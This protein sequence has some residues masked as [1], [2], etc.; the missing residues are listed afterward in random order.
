MEDYM[1]WRIG[2]GRWQNEPLT[3]QAA[4]AVLEKIP[5]PERVSAIDGL[6]ECDGAA[7]KSL[8][9]SRLKRI[10]FHGRSPGDG[11]LPAYCVGIKI[12]VI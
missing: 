7:I 5:Y 3:D 1:K 11:A 9:N 10:P 4:A 12:V 8:H 6:L 2:N